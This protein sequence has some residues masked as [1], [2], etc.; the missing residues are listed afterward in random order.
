MPLRRKSIVSD[1]VRMVALARYRQLHSSAAP[2]DKLSKRTRGNKPRD[3]TLEEVESDTRKQLM[4]MME[5]MVA[6][7]NSMRSIKYGITCASV[8]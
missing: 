2:K 3:I 4:Q 6:E 5:R 7:M 8:H 1:A